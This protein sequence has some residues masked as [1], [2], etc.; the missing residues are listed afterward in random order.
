MK[1]SM[2]VGVLVII[3]AAL[4]CACFAGEPEPTVA[5]T[6]ATIE[7]T[8]PPE[9]EAATEPPETEA[10][11]EPTEPAAPSLGMPAGSYL[12]YY[13]D[14]ETGDYLNYYIH[15]PENATEGMPL[16]IF[17]HGDG[18]VGNPYLLKE[19]GAINKIRRIYGDNFPF[20]SIAPN[21]RQKTWIDG[22]IPATLKGLIDTVIEMY[23]CDTEHII[24]TGH[25]RGAVGV[26]DMISIYGDYFSAAMPISSPHWVGHINYDNAAKVAVWT[27][28]GN[29][30]ETECW[31]HKYL[32][33]NVDQ[34]NNRGGTAKFTILEG[35]NHGA[36]KSAALSSYSI[37]WLLSQ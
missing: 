36:A 4:L 3:I 23:S 11:T 35:C 31:Y 15:F 7:Q 19:G 14:P 17:L 6:E 25:S 26:W 27:F 22:K 10:A 28:A 24:I 30:G 34:I 21:T 20:I 18:E 37:E 5:L 12:D 32:Q 33:Q 8:M 16:F 2:C 13:S 9:T 29:I 1:R